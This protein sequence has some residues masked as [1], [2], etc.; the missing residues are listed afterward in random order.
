ME[1]GL[2]GQT[3]GARQPQ[4]QTLVQGPAMAPTSRS[5]SPRV[6]GWLQISFSATSKAP[7]MLLSI[8]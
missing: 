2:K 8:Q 6:L 4:V 7:S 3:A 5:R 1:M